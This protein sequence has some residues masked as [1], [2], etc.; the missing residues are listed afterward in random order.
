M[1]VCRRYVRMKGR[2]NFGGTRACLVC[3][4][5]I[6]MLTK[7]LCSLCFIVCKSPNTSIDLII[8]ISVVLESVTAAAGTNSSL[9]NKSTS[10]TSLSNL[11]LRYR[12]CEW[13]TQR[14]APSLFWICKW[15]C[16]CHGPTPRLVVIRHDTQA[17]HRRKSRRRNRRRNLRARLLWNRRPC[18]QMCPPLRH[19]PHLRS[20]PVRPPPRNPPLL[21]P[22]SPQWHPPL[23]H[24]HSLQWHPS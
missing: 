19:L 14:A 3:L 17:L 2:N 4:N 16:F 1:F 22:H 13:S 18:L 20:R 23:L 12:N 10:K 15:K 7:Q 11:V 9:P 24:P 8:G 5:V 21:H 6:M